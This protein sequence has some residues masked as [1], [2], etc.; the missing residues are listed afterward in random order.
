[1]TDDD[2]YNRGFVNGRRDGYVD[3]VAVINDLADDARK[4]GDKDYADRLIHVA[5]EVRG[6]YPAVD[7]AYYARLQESLAV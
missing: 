6:R 4:A 5:A 7:A 3:A 1:M 2:L